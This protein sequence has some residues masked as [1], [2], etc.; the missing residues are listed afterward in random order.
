MDP[1]PITQKAAAA[2]ETPADNEKPNEANEDGGSLNGPVTEP[3]LAEKVP[4]LAECPVVAPA[5]DEASETPDS[6][7]ESTTVDILADEIGEM[8]ITPDDLPCDSIAVGIDHEPVE[9]VTADAP[10]PSELVEQPSERPEIEIPAAAVAAPAPDQAVDLVDADTPAPVTAVEA[11]A[12]V[13]DGDAAS[14]PDSHDT[15][16]P[17]PLEGL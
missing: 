15:A 2:P 4:D 16:P 10:P 12:I 6:R 13:D 7:P 5:K 9:P 1:P 11:E 14:K 3:D 17:H 8:S